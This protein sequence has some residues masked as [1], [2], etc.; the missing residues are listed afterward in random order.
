M[1]N[2]DIAGRG[3]TGDTRQ[4]QPDSGIMEA[5][6][7]TCIPM[8]ELRIISA[9]IYNLMQ[10]LIVNGNSDLCCSRA[11][12]SLVNYRLIPLRYTDTRPGRESTP[13]GS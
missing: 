13:A 6:A 2:P 9:G 5:D 12:S 1:P 4:R 10:P 3:Q 8:E 11:F 7:V